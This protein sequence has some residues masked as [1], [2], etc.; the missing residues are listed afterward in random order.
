MF[1]NLNDDELQNLKSSECLNVGI[2]REISL[3]K[4]KLVEEKFKFV[5]SS[6]SH[7]DM[8][9]KSFN[10]TILDINKICRGG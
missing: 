1:T 8:F 6:L 5:R 9:L 7:C 2:L 4:P 10:R 3:V